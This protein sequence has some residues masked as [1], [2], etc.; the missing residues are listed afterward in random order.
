[1][2]FCPECGSKLTEGTKFCSNCGFKVL[3]VNEKKVTSEELVKKIL[4][5]SKE[6]G[7]AVTPDIPDKKLIMVTKS[8]SDNIDPVKV[9]GIVD[10][11]AFSNGK[12]GLL[13]TGEESYIKEPFSELK[14]VPYIG[15]NEVDYNL[16]QEILEN[17]KVKEKKKLIIRYN[18][19]IV[20]IYTETN[21]PLSILADILVGI[22]D[23]VDSI[24]S[25]NQIVQLQNLDPIIIELYFRI[26]ICY[27]KLDDGVIDKNEYKELISLMTKLRISKD[28]ADKLREYRFSENQEDIDE[29][30]QSLKEKL[31]EQ[32]ISSNAIFQSLGMDIISMNLGIL[33]DWESDES[34]VSVLDKLGITDKQVEFTIRKIQMEKRIIEER[35]DDGQIKAI[36][37][38]LSALAAGAGIS[39]GALAI[40]GA[41]S[42]WGGI[43]GGLLALGLGS[44]GAFIGAVAVAAGAYGVYRGIKSIAGTGEAEKYGIRIAALTKKIEILRAS[45]V[46]II[47]DINY[48]NDETTT[49]INSIEEYKENI[50][51]LMPIIKKLMMKSKNVS[52]SGKLVENEQVNSEK[53]LII[54]QLPEVLDEDKFIELNKNS[55]HRI[56][57]ANIIYKAYMFN[58]DLNNV[59]ELD[60]NE[61]VVM[62]EDKKLYLVEDESNEFLELAYKVLQDVGYYN[63][64]TSSVAQGKVAAKKG[65][66]SI[67][68]GLFGK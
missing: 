2:N 68:K 66:E 64:T 11:S 63:T 21:F 45:N 32:K 36:L 29:L 60:N 41:V 35:M 49:L 55:I 65:F 59:N 44:A 8:F 24:D 14:K 28:I 31:Q 33:N 50:D 15:I 39:L 27:L 16:E 37:T 26:I 18:D 58:S 43:S 62:T 25:Y 3:D 53:E 6:P 57:N 9:I 47:D 56:E 42:G 20:E 52:E 4:L 48:L 40:T 51:K 5:E 17:G 34:L 54:T 13:F 23:K 38:E 46:Y 7:I 22:K 61:D 10:T 12:A 1:M 19:E 30:L 67:K